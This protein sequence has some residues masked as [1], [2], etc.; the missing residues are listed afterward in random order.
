M[1]R[2]ALALV[3]I[4]SPASA[5]SLWSQAGPSPSSLYAD[6]VAYRRGDILTVIIRE[7]Q[8]LA[9]DEE[10]DLQKDGSLDARLEEFGLKPNAFQPLPT[11]KGNFTRDFQGTGKIDKDGLFEA[12]ISVIVLDVQPN[13][14]LVVEGKRNIILGDERK[15]IRLTGLVRPQDVSSTNTIRS[16]NVANAAIAF[17]GNGSVTRTT[18]RG[19][20][21]R[22]LDFVWPF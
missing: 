1:R 21:S 6:N 19:W 20:F 8:R 2:I 3:L 18:S 9:I 15:L 16:E 7:Q 13:G 11:V 22:F 12:R 4:A 14:N 17:E 10:T 5:Q